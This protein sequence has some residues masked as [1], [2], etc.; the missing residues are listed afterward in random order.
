MQIIDK[1]ISNFTNNKSLYIG[2]KV[3]MSEH[4]IQTAMLAEKAKCNDDLICSCLLHDYGHFILENPDE[5]VK[6][7]L[8]GKHEDIG[9]EYLKRIFKKE[10]TEPIK[11]HVLAKRYLAKDKK[12]LAVI[13]KNGLWIKDKQEDGTLIINAEKIENEFLI[14]S[15][16]T[17]FDENFFIKKNIIA[18]KIDVKKKEW[19]LFD[20]IVTGLDNSS[21][22]YQNIKFMTNFDLKKISNLFSD[23]TSLTYLDLLSLEKDYK[24]IGYSTSE[25]NIQKH[26]FYSLPFLLSAMTIIA[27]II[28]IYN[29]FKDKILLNLFIGILFSEHSFL[30]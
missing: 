16:I 8:D 28:M 22:K 9:Y 25:I 29:K 30:I 7:N 11:Y 2:E 1:I 4:M 10:I 6:E 26:R 5:L 14:N 23:L 18:T 17:Q 19:I 12:Y 24:A 21:N 15:S 20:A 3:T 13:T 27:S